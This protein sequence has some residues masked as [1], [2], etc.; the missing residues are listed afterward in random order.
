MKLT[1]KVRQKVIL[2]ILDGKY[3]PGD[4]LPT[5]RD[6]TV[7][8]QTSRITVRRAYEQLERNGVSFPA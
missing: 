6:M 4:K 5:E 2:D 1:E 3:S 8:T 7:I